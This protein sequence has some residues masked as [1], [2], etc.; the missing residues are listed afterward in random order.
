MTTAAIAS[1]GLRTIGRLGWWLSVRHSAA[2]QSAGADQEQIEYLNAHATGTQLGNGLGGH[3][4]CPVL[5]RG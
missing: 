4:G 1:P 3:K 5:G 2:L